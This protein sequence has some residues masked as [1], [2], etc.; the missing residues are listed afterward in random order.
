MLQVE[1]LKQVH[2]SYPINIDLFQKNATKLKTD[3][4]NL[5]DNVNIGI[6]SLSDLKDSNF[7]NYDF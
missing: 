6:A 7:S 1:K 2:I 4:Q 5:F 3:S